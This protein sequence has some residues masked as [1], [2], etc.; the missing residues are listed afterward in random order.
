MVGVRV[1]HRGWAAAFAIL[2]ASRS[3]TT[4]VPRKGL[5]V[6][7]GCYQGLLPGVEA[8]IRMRPG[9]GTDEHSGS[10]SGSPYP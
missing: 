10:G 3:A 1:H 4:L 2:M 6:G 9:L 5:R 8:S 7:W